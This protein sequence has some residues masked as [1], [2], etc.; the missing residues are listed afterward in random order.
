MDMDSTFTIAFEQ[1]HEDSALESVP[2]NIHEFPCDW[3]GSGELPRRIAEFVCGRDYNTWL[4]PAGYAVLAYAVTG[5]ANVD[6]K[7]MHRAVT[8][9]KHYLRT[10]PVGA[11][12]V[13]RV[14]RESSM[15]NRR[16]KKVYRA[17][18]SKFNS[19]VTRTGMTYDRFVKTLRADKH[20]SDTA[21]FRVF[22]LLSV[23][24][25]ITESVVLTQTFSADVDPAFDGNMWISDIAGRVSE[26]IEAF[27]ELGNRPTKQGVIGDLERSEY[28]TNYAMLVESVNVEITEIESLSNLLGEMLT[29]KKQQDSESRI[30][31]LRVMRERLYAQIPRRVESELNRDTLSLAT[32]NISDAHA[33]VD[34]AWAELV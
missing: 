12:G 3:D 8:S 15:F 1:L 34:K 13:E 23:L 20:I 32:L 5:S 25:S 28:D 31:E 22:Q 21:P 6:S 33:A 30:G 2:K 29:V 14:A 26:L 24:A 16:V 17:A 4:K 11:G 9:V 7:R 10:A 18:A 19:Q 27:L